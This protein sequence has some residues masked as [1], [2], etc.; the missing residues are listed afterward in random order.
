MVDTTPIRPRPV[1]GS[2]REARSGRKGALLVR[3]AHTTDPKLIGI[4]YTVT[5]FAFFPAA[6]S[7]RC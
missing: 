2:L 1:P 6:I 7:W 5:A 4:M 3:V